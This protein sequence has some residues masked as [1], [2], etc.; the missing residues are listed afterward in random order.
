MALNLKKVLKTIEKELDKEWGNLDF[1]YSIED[2][3]ATVTADLT[4]NNHDDDIKTMITVFE[5]GAA[6]FRA[7]FDEIEKTPRVLSLLNDFNC[8]HPFFTAFVRED[9]FL[10]LRHFVFLS[11]ENAIN[12]YPS[13]F[14]IRLA[15]LAD[16][17]TLLKLTRFTY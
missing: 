10:E 9:G 1:E 7:V 8:E 14:L 13:E 4:L 16:S 15:N 2:D 11:D 5:G 6:V 12:E 17:E 3:T